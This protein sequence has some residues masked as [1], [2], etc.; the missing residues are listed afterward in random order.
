VT[1]LS[2]LERSK[3][4]ELADLLIPRASGMP[5]GA[6]A[7]VHG[8]YID[9]VFEVRPDLIDLVRSGLEEVPEPLPSTFEALEALKPT[10]LRPLAD[11]VTAAYFLN[12]EVS[13]LVGYRKR[14]VIP[15][16][17]DDDLGE[18]VSRVVARGPIYRPTPASDAPETAGRP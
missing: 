14:S 4:G 10:H 15:I 8:E 11:A 6:E 3:L 2:R 12:P 16:R 7:D 17:F 1:A 18:L 9:R 13:R 5:S